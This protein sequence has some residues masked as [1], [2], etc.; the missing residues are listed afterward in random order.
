ML[1]LFLGLGAVISLAYAY[2]ALRTRRRAPCTLH[3]RELKENVASLNDFCGDAFAREYNELHVALSQVIDYAVMKLLDQ[4]VPI[5]AQQEHGH[6]KM[7]HASMESSR[8][9]GGSLFRWGWLLAFADLLLLRCGRPLSCLLCGAFESGAHTMWGLH[10]RLDPSFLTSCNA[11]HMME[12]CEHGVIT[13]ET[14]KKRTTLI[15][16]TV[17]FPLAI[18]VI[19]IVYLAPPIV[20]LISQ[21]SLL[22]HRRTYPQ[23]AYYLE[24]GALSVVEQTLVMFVHWILPIPFSERHRSNRYNGF[25]SL[26]RDRGLKYVVTKKEELSWSTY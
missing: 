13:T 7:N 15:D 5:L 1:F 6:A 4:E 23:L 12:E 11:F 8:K 24:L 20:L 2:D 3:L 19:I 17:T 14:L 25:I 18:L 26:C 22:H 10:S 9:Q 21:P 16:R